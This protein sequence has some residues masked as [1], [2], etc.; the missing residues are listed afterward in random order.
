MNKKTSNE[1]TVKENTEVAAFVAPDFQSEAVN[2]EDIVFPRIQL[3]QPISETVTDGKYAAGDIIDSVSGEVM[4][5]PS[6]SVEIIPLRCRK[7]YKVTKKV[8]GKDK[9][10]RI[11]PI[12]SPADMQKEWNFVEE[13]EQ[14]AR[15]PVMEI[16]VLVEGQEIPYI[17]R[18]SGMSFKG[19]GKSFYTAAFALPASQ[20]KAPFVRSLLITSKKEK[21]DKG[22]YFVYSF[23]N[24]KLSDADT[25]ALANQWYEST[26]N[27]KVREEDTNEDNETPPSVPVDAGF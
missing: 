17:F 15:R 8:D 4:G 6:K 25:Y 21:N 9:Y 1:L 22:V 13:G 23:V 14:L 19:I 2:V 12:N 5:S 27:V 24:G 3:L 20:R 16:F 26:K 18:L 7:Y 11:E 10:V